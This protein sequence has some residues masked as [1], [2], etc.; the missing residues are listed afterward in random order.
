MRQCSSKSAETINNLFQRFDDFW[1]GCSPKKKIFTY[2][3]I[4]T[5]IFSL[6][7]VI[8]YSPFIV[9]EKSFIWASDGRYQHWPA[10][11][12]VGKW[13]REFAHNL[14]NGTPAFKMFDISIGMGSDVIGTL[15]WYGFG[16]PLNVIAFFVPTKYTEY[17]QIVLSIFRV[18]LSGI[19]F[20]LL[21]FYFNQEKS[22]TLIGAIVY[23]FS[24]FATCNSTT[25]PFFINPLIH[26]PLLIIGIDMILSKKKP[27]VFVFAVSY[28][29]LCGF[30][31]LYMMT[32][33]VGVYFLLRLFFS[34]NKPGFSE[35]FHIALK[36]GLMYILGIGIVA[37]IFLPSCLAF[38]ESTTDRGSMTDWLF[39]SL[40][41]YKDT[42]LAFFSPYISFSE[43]N[44]QSLPAIVLFAIITLLGFH[45]DKSMLKT[46]LILSLCIFFSPLGGLVMNGFSYSVNRWTFTLAL[47]CSYIVVVEAKNLFEMSHNKIR[48]CIAVCTLYAFC[49]LLIKPSAKTHYT[50]M[51]AFFSVLT[52]L[53]ILFLQPICLDFCLGKVY[54]EKT[55]KYFVRLVSLLLVVSNVGIFGIYSYSSSFGGFSNEFPTIG[56]RSKELETHYMKEVQPY[57]LKNPIGRADF[58]AKSSFRNIGMLYQIPTI[59][60]YWSVSNKYVAEFWKEIESPGLRSSFNLHNT[61]WRVVPSALQSVKYFVGTQKD[62]AKIPFGYSLFK[63]NEGKQIYKNDYALPW[64][65][66]YDSS[67]PLSKISTMNGLEKQERMLYSII[68]EDE[69]AFTNF[70]SSKSDIEK[71]EYQSVFKDCSLSDGKISVSKAG[72]TVS[73]SFEMPFSTEGYLL[74]KGLRTEK[75]SFTLEVNCNDVTKLAY[76]F[77][78]TALRYYDHENYL[79]NLGY[80]ENTYST[81]TITFPSKG[82]FDLKDISLYALPM[83]NYIEQVEALRAE[84]LEN[85]QWETN[86][87]SG[88]VDLSKDKILCMSIPYS[89]GWTA[90]VDGQKAEILRG[91][92]M[93]MA[94]PLTEGHHEVE[95]EYCS[96]GLKTGLL[97]SIVSVLVFISMLLYDRKNNRNK[98][99]KED[100]KA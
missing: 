87:I 76:V 66:T 40:S 83:D 60:S 74:L 50:Y 95:F 97:V 75:S 52:F 79:F 16:D 98:K 28:A 5:M 31:F 44:F 36:A 51:G 91:N 45:K 26:L 59:P 54:T 69:V 96:P 39:Y 63:E 37:L 70:S 47:I 84:P 8:T 41:W 29:A 71:V 93:F 80:C 49:L 89:K 2:I 72:A 68:L 6:T 17:L 92:Y 10:L 12:Y 61:D 48:I 64:G 65:Y 30:Y 78:P 19:C 7:A 100:Y 46:M 15:N 94:V 77:S 58:P 18:Y 57:L 33:V 23:C 43:C 86:K 25:E 4:Y 99:G 11:I 3:C 90:T 88:T 56:T 81:L 38:F 21:C 22:F 20:S 82:T 53:V 42:L 13:L 24:G 55:K 9:E 35:A 85:I 62:H 34:K 67:I 32:V 73:L 1:N 27:Y 14:I